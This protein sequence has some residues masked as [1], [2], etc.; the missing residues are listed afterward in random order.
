VSDTES[1]QE[2][3]G[4][5]RLRVWAGLVARGT[6]LTAWCKANGVAHQNASKALSGAWTGPKAEALVQ[7]LMIAAGV[8]E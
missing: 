5:I 7:R 3:E 1:E 6:T 4:H 2:G 8:K